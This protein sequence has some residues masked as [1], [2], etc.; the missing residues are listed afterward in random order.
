[1]SKIIEIRDIE[2]KR[3][4]LMESKDAAFAGCSN[5][6]L[7]PGE[8]ACMSAGI[9]CAAHNRKG[10]RQWREAPPTVEEFDSVVTKRTGDSVEITLTPKPQG[11]AAGLK[12][13]GG[14]ASWSLLMRGC[15]RA[16]RAVVGVLDFGAQKYAADSWQQVENARERYKDALYRHMH[17][18]ELRGFTAR[19]PETGKLE[20]AHV[21][22]NALFLLSFALMDEGKDE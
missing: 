17:Q 16:L 7:E 6:V 21:A 18:I 3:L 10:Y 1:M 5:C 11:K 14:K 20:W 12:Y 19:D 9:G 4:A 22:C 15:G 13:D 2:G 8:S